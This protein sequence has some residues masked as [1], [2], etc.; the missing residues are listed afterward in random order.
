MLAFQAF[1]PD[2]CPQPHYLPFVTAAG[3]FFLETDDI[4]Q[5]Y[6]R[7]HFCLETLVSGYEVSVDRWWLIWSRSSVATRRAA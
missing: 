5:L 3:V 7:N 1:N 6:F 4:A 2:V